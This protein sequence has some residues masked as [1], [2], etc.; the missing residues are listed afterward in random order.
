MKFCLFQ[1]P[2][3]RRFA[4]RIIPHPSNRK[5]SL[6]VIPLK[7]SLWVDSHNCKTDQIQLTHLQVGKTRTNPNL[8][9]FEEAGHWRSVFPKLR[10]KSGRAKGLKARPRLHTR[11]FRVLP[12]RIGKTWHGDCVFKYYANPFSKYPGNHSF[13]LALMYPRKESL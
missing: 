6:R 9:W 11:F 1:E 10:S 2:S 3:T 13:L 4:R 5:E 7:H 8:A 12:Y